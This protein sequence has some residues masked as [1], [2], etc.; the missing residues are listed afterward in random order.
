M[1][2]KSVDFN[3]VANSFVAAVGTHVAPSFAA[4]TASS[5]LQIIESLVPLA[6]AEVAR[7]MPGL[8]DRLAGAMLH[9]SDQTVRP[10]EANLSI[11]ARN[12]LQKNAA[13]FQRGA[14]AAISAA[15]LAEIA[16]LHCPGSAITSLEP[17]DLTL[18]SLDEMENK[19]LIDAIGQAI[20][21]T[22][23]SA[24][25]GLNIRLSRLLKRAELSTAQN[26]FRPALFLR[27]VFD[28]WCK[29]DPHDD[30]HRLILRLFRSE[31]FFDFA[32]LLAALNQALVARGVVPDLAEAY[33]RSR[34]TRQ[35]PVCP[36]VERRDASLQNKVHRWLEKTGEDDA[37]GKKQ[38]RSASVVADGTRSANETASETASKIGS[39]TASVTSLP[40]ILISYLSGLPQAS[41]QTMQS[42]KV[43]GSEYT[44]DFLRDISRNAPTNV[45]G[46]AHHNIITLLAEMFDAVFSDTTISSSLKK[47]V[48]QLQLPLLKTALLDTDFFYKES[49]PARRLL[50]Q[51]AQAGIG[52]HA[53]AQVPDPL[54]K[55]IEQLIDRVQ[56]ESALQLDLYTDV[57]TDLQSY[58]AAQERD[59]KDAL[60]THIAEALQEEKTQQAQQ[61]AENDIAVRIETGEVAGFVEVFLE[62]QWVRVLTMTHRV[63]KR[64]PKALANALKAMDQLIWSVKPKVTQEQ[65]SELITTLPSM[66]S[67]INAW[68]NAIKWDGAERVRFFSRL[69]ERH[70]A[71]VQGPVELTPRHQLH[72]AVNVAQKASERRLS[73]RARELEAPPVDQFVHLVDSLEVGTWI[74]FVRHNGVAAP[75]RLV[76]LSPLRTRF[77]FCNQRYD[78]PFSFTAEELALAL[79]EQGA[80]L[81]AQESFSTRALSAALD[82]LDRDK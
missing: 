38:K 46:E 23:S 39:K 57:V 55:M 21:L 63:A 42:T 78:E 56:R 15:L 32:P 49:H 81:L 62:T 40:P 58:L 50:D 61:A 48:A 6:V 4:S 36:E 77:M 82:S 72:L 20:D 11:N 30:A 1:S 79:R 25:V 19:V 14:L 18:V 22:N 71:L 80:T 59:A 29:F 8:I 51:L 33:R 16:T 68:L 43:A 73:R 64:K 70:A 75:F 37:R 9:L 47:L 74:E 35:P 67:L 12:H 76:W 66:L 24:L 13:L 52:M 26:P 27:A 28:A 54:T 3:P 34:S 53:G 45:I 2:D 5:R 7:Q 10:N 41:L 17:R 44:A 31:L 60:K 69:V 65:R